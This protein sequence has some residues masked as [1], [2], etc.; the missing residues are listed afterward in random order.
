MKWSRERYGGGKF[1]QRISTD[2]GGRVSSYSVLRT[3]SGSGACG[4]DG[5]S[6]SDSITIVLLA[7]L[8]TEL[9]RIE[10]AEYLTA[11]ALPRNSGWLRVPGYEWTSNCM[12]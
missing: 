10:S 7:I 3:P 6:C 1:N 9:A 4:A 5:E 8:I 12:Q 11:V 2:I